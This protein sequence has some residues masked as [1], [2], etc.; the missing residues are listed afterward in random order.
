M[1]AAYAALPPLCARGR[2]IAAM[3][4][5]AAA[6]LGTNLPDGTRFLGTE[7]LGTP[8][9]RPG[10]DAP[11]ADDLSACVA[12]GLCLPHCPTYRLTGDALGS[13]AQF[14]DERR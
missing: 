14:C 12:C 7:T 2:S 11:T 9:W 1:R 4:P 10:R 8:G 5:H 13:A 6:P 3:D